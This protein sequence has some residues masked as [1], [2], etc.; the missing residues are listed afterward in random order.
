MKPP[1]NR[2]GRPVGTP[3]ALPL[4]SVAAIKAMR[5]RVPEAI[6]PQLGEL[7]DEA[8]NTVVNVMRRADSESSRGDTVKLSAARIVRDEI[9]GPMPKTVEHEVNGDVTINVLTSIPRTPNSEGA[10]SPE[11]LDVLLVSNDGDDE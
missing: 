10:E 6:S 3:N 5:H 8:F 4:G 1:P 7:A 9:C 2:N 11:I